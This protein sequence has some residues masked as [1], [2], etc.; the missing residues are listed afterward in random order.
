MKKTYDVGTHLNCLEKSRQFKRVST[1]YDY[2]KKTENNIAL[3]SLNTLLMKSS[4]DL[5]FKCALSSGYFTTSFPST[6]EKFKRTV[7]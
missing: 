5:S 1:K 7:R 4:V 3:A 6:F 2:I